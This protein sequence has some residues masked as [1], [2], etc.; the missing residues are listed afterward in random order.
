MDD[1]HTQAEA[2]GIEVDADTVARAY[3]VPVAFFMAEMRRGNV[4]AFVERG[5]GEDA[6]RY[7]LNFSYRG[8]A[9]RMVLDRGELVAEEILPA[10][11]CRDLVAQP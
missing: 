9:L 8:R 3:S 10:A 1:S 5:E 11:A 2:A 4:K 7:R 6:G